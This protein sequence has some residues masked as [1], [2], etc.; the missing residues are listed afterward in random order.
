MWQLSGLS[1]HVAQ[2]TSNA[3]S[4]KASN[5]LVWKIVVSIRWDWN[6]SSILYTPYRLY[7][8]DINVLQMPP[9]MFSKYAPMIILS[10]FK[11]PT[12]TTKCKCQQKYY[13]CL[14]NEWLNFLLIVVF[15]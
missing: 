3:N 10:L 6:V 2:E 4:D 7:V 1:E 9:I 13:M 5:D 11:V 14:L 15:I 12:C 8:L